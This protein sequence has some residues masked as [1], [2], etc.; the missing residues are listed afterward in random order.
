[1]PDGD[2]V[3]LSST[4]TEAGG[5][6]AYR[7]G[8]HVS[9][10]ALVR[11]ARLGLE[12]RWTRWAGSYKQS[13]V[14]TSSGATIATAT[15]GL[16]VDAGASVRLGLAWRPGVEFEADR[17]ALSSSLGVLENAGRYYVHQPTRVVGGGAAQ[18]SRKVAV[19]GQ[20]DYVRYSE[21][22][23]AVRIGAGSPD[24]YAGKDAFE[25]RFGV[26]ISLP[27]RAASVQLRAGV[28]AQQESG[29]VYS[30]QD[31]SLKTT[32]AGVGGQTRFTAGVSVV[33]RAGFRVDAAA[34][35]GGLRSLV[36]VGAGVEF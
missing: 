32:W 22:A 4:V 33:T 34:Q 25:P 10:G 23:S 20:V 3:D 35:A 15:V 8:S 14:G 36:I 17:T 31:G 1:V 28:H 13:E 7:V 21:V 29:I 11:V 30:G 27:L 19:V 6:A 24:E 9:V 16:L 5:G 12:G 18:L 2:V 26:E